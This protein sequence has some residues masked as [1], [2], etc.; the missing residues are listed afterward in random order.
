MKGRDQHSAG[1]GGCRGQQVQRQEGQQSIV[2]GNGLLNSA[3]ERESC[4][5]GKE[6]T[7]EK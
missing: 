1:G 2:M 7:G 3:E 5:M 6:N 4:V